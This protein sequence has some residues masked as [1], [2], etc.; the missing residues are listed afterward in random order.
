MSRP[1]SQQEQSGQARA[2]EPAEPNARALPGAWSRFSG[3]IGV[4]IAA[5]VLVAAA[6]LAVFAPV[7]ASD[8]PLALRAVDHGG[9]EAAL[10][11]MGS[12]ALSLNSSL[13]A[14]LGAQPTTGSAE[15]F[16]AVRG[17]GLALAKCLESVGPW[18]DNGWRA[19]VWE[20]ESALQEL[21]GQLDQPQAQAR[22]VQLA[23]QVEALR[24]DLTRGMELGAAEAA[25]EGT[26]S[27]ANQTPGQSGALHLRAR[28]S[29]PALGDLAGWERAL[30]ACTLLLGPV[31]LWLRKRTQ[32]TLF[33]LWIGIAF[34]ALG[35]W[36]LSAGMATLFARQG[37]DSRR[38][39]TRNLESEDIEVEW[40]LNSPLGAGA[41]G[42]DLEHSSHGPSW[43]TRTSNRG[44]GQKLQCNGEEFHLL[45]TDSLGRDLSARLLHGS[46]I[47]L[48]VA[49]LATLAMSIMGIGLGALAAM[50]GRLTDACVMRAIEW[51]SSFPAF[52]LVLAAVALV[53]EDRLHPLASIVLFISLVGWTEIARLVRSELLALTKA[54]SALAARSLG[55]SPLRI[56]C[57]HLL[58]AALGPVFVAMAFAAAGTVLF[59]SGVSFLGFG[60]R[61]PD[62]SLGALLAEERGAGSWWM[63]VFP[64]LAIFVLVLCANAL[65]EGLRR[66]LDP[67]AEEGR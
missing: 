2:V 67:R 16:A 62:P 32:R 22:S 1:G 48:S 12:I 49:L 17:E 46:R 34:V 18:V 60:V 44:P 53:P 41:R 3:L 4:R 56:L 42:T 7:L 54:D 27:A 11:N 36:A 9:F 39:T 59:E 57:K 29:F 37:V 35:T 15:P 55:L 30:I 58:P 28:T 5:A 8:K 45:G 47:S 20:T 25:G 65:G 52:F 64:G 33:R 51:L 50:G 31:L 23:T 13:E 66:A 21:L 61:N 26:A 63:Q 24:R 6:V 43:S 40:Q 14:A 10:D 19:R 38:V